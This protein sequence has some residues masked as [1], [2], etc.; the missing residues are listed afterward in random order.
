MRNRARKLYLR[1]HGYGLQALDLNHPGFSG[2][3]QTDPESAVRILRKSDVELMYWSAASLGMAVSVSRNDVSL[4][5][6]LPEV[7]SLLNRA[8]ELDEGWN[9]GALHEFKITLAAGRP[10]GAAPDQL[11]PHYDRALQLSKSKSASLFV[12]YAEAVPLPQRKRAE[13]EST[14]RKALE[15][16]ADERK[17][18][19]L[20]TLVAQQRANWLLGRA[21]ELFLTEP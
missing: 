3:L 2:K 11:Q 21:D 20:L 6:R 16:D 8:L 7:E 13:F 5:A 19:R 9:A 12:A 10:G 1:A 14:L 17:E 15:I 4:L 18:S